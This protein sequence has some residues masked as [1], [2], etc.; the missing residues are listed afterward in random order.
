MYLATLDLTACCP[1]LSVQLSSWKARLVVPAEAGLEVQLLGQAL[2]ALP[3]VPREARA[4]PGVAAISSDDPA[5][6]APTSR[7]SRR[8]RRHPPCDLGQVTSP[9]VPQCR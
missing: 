9:L 7:S 2:R 4:I 6:A 1:A 5:R 8:L 3:Q